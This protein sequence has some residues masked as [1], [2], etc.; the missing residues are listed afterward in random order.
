MDSG[1]TTGKRPGAAEVRAQQLG[2]LLA[3]A[4]GQ[5]G[6]DL[7]VLGDEALDPGRVTGDGRRGDPLVA[8]SERVVGAGEQRVAGGRDERAVETTVGLREARAGGTQRALL[9]G[10]R[11]LQL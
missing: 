6:R 8:V 9:R 5:R 3:L 10:D 4:R 1:A 2:R 11:G 7:A